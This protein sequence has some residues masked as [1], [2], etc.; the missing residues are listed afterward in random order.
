MGRQLPRDASPHTLIAGLALSSTGQHELA[1]AE[2][3]KAI[4]LDPERTPAYGN[5]AYN[6]LRLNRLD[7]CV[8]DRPSSGGAQAGIRS[9]A[10]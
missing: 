6:Q 7:D 9:V 5:K 3:E 4:A 10:L 8:A 2:T 1:I